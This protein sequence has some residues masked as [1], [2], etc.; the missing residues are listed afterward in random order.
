MPINQHTLAEVALRERLV[1]EFLAGK[2]PAHG[3]NQTYRLMRALCRE[4]PSECVNYPLR[5][6]PDAPREAA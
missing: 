6:V 5:R 2:I 3:H 4:T 1:R